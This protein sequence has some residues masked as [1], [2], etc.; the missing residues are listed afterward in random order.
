MSASALSKA[1]LCVSSVR[2]GG[3][4]FLGVDLG[5]RSGGAVLFS[6][7]GGTSG[8]PAGGDSERDGGRVLVGARTPGDW[9][10]GSRRERMINNS[11]PTVMTTAAP[12]LRRQPPIPRTT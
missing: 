10:A 6:S 7:R 1:D 12:S 3:G 2:A 8:F 4:D 9:R 5:G 11:P